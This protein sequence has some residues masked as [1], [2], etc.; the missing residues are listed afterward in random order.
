[1][2]H[3]ATWTIAWLLALSFAAWAFGALRYDS[4]C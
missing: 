1:V 2:V 3:G 4:R